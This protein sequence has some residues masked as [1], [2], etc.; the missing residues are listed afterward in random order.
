MSDHSPATGPGAPGEPSVTRPTFSPWL[1]LKSS[2][3]LLSLGADALSPQLL[4][5]SAVAQLR[6]PQRRHMT[7]SS[8]EGSV[9]LGEH[10]RD[11]AKVEAPG[12][13][14]AGHGARLLAQKR[15]KR[16]R[17]PCK[18]GR[19]R[20]AN[21]L[22]RARPG[23]VEQPLLPGAEWVFC[24]AAR[25]NAIARRWEE[26]HGPA[27]LQAKQGSVSR[28]GFVVCSARAAAAEMGQVRWRSVGAPWRSCCGGDRGAVLFAAC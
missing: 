12:R 10:T 6:T 3:R 11:G 25:R 26:G 28:I 13:T 9:D 2:D 7:V 23:A 21:G 14:L 16:R 19:R 24:L 22:L 15:R 5:Y 8:R 18:N 20:P 4:Q 1:S 27:S 17:K